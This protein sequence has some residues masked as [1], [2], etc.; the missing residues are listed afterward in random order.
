MKR[1]VLIVDDSEY[2][3]NYHA[4]ILRAAGFEIVGTCAEHRGVRAGAPR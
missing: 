3:R 2:T 1:S 4:Y